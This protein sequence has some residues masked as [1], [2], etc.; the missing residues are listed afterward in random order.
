MQVNSVGSITRSTRS[1]TVKLLDPEDSVLTS[2][3][4]SIRAVMATCGDTSESEAVESEA[5]ESDTVESD[6]AWGD[7]VGDDTA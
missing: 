2:W 3:E 7:T 6:S 5:V 4:H 1:R